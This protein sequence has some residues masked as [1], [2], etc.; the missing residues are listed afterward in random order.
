MARA[1]LT[2]TVFT[3]PSKGRLQLHNAGEFISI[4]LLIIIKKMEL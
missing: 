2:E 3:I 4:Q 1:L